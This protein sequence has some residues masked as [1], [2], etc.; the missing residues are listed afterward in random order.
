M[1]PLFVTPSGGAVAGASPDDGAGFGTQYR[2]AHGSSSGGDRPSQEW[3]AARWARVLGLLAVMVCTVGLQYTYGLLLVA[4][5]AALPTE[6]FAVLV[7]VGSL[8][9]GVMELSAVASGAVMLRWGERR[10]CVCGGLLAG[11]GLLMSSFA[12]QGWH[13]VVAYGLV[14]GLG[15]S[16][17]LFPA[18]ITIN[19]AFSKRRSLAAGIGCSGGGLGTLGFGVCVPRLLEGVG[20]AWTMRI[21]AAIVAVLCCSA[22]LILT[23]P[24]PEQNPTQRDQGLGNGGLPA[25]AG[26]AA[27]LSQSSRWWD[28]TRSWSVRLCCFG[29][30]V[31]SC[32]LFTPIVTLV[33]FAVQNGWRLEDSSWLV[34]FVGVGGLTFRLP[35]SAA[36]DLTGPRQAIVAILYLDG[37]LLACAG[38][39]ILV[40]NFSVMI[41]YSVSFGGLL[42]CF[43]T[44]TAPMMAALAEAE[45]MTHVTTLA[46]TCVGSGFMAGPAVLV[47]VFPANLNHAVLSSGILVILGGAVVHSVSLACMGP[48]SCVR[49]AR[50]SSVPGA[51]MTS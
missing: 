7:S 6:S 36:A 33:E 50:D 37:I 51:G 12:T 44:I 43:L 18:V 13:L 29:L 30:F 42:G 32:G 5:Q 21:L 17:S 47:A 23:D 34:G 41:A 20:L 31:A 1:R 45:H 9:N 8:S 16:L 49:A 40:D 35:V 19:K 26:A 38:S 14:V 11:L 28:A 15:N 3:E 48:G 10:T 2:R 4:Y 24:F 46:F 27:G 25:V 22:G 39:G